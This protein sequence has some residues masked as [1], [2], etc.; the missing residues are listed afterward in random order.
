MFPLSVVIITKNEEKYIARCL[1]SVSWADDVLVVDSESTDQTL[2]IVRAQGQPWSSRVRVLTRSWSGF[3]D[4]R[5]FA[6]QNAKY[7]WVLSMDA[8]EACSAELAEK[9]QSLLRDPKGPPSAAYQIRRV[10]YFLGK[11]ID[12]G[13]WNP[14][15]QDRFFHK[16]GVRY[17]NN[18]HEY[19]VFSVIPSQI[20]EPIHHCLDLDPEKILAKMNRYTS[21][22]ARDRVNHGQRTNLFHLLGTFP[23]M[24]LKV[25]FY[26]GG[27]KDGM[28]GL[29][30]ALLEG[31]SRVVR[32]IKMW[33]YQNHSDPGS[34]L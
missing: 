14:S 1:E 4:Q 5:N 16:A 15:Y 10:E 13:I 28:R 32:H 25:Y 12:Y 6:L 23:V 33:Q 17:V 24:T 27:Y 18:V 20:H 3:R 7:D 30:I 22:E 9:I 21:I 19:P 34:S 8:D 11:P 2:E 29:I 26:Y 31:V